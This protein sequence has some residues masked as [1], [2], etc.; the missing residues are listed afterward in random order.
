[1]LTIGHDAQT[2]SSRWLSQTSSFLAAFSLDG[3][4]LTSVI[5]YP[6]TQWSF[7]YQSLAVNFEDSNTQGRQL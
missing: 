5:Q 7:V 2:T 3:Y 4:S 1:M 6:S